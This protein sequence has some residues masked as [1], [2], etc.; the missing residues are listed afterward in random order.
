[1]LSSV[2]F[3]AS[4]SMLLWAQ[5][6]SSRRSPRSQQFERFFGADRGVAVTV[7][8]RYREL[9]RIPD[10]VD[11]FRYLALHGAVG[12]STF[13]FDRWINQQFYRSAQWKQ[14]RHY[15]IARD[16][17]CD[18]GVEGHE[19]YDRV[20]IHHMNPMLPDDI[21]HQHEDILDPEFLITVSHNTH[22][23]IHYGDERLL[24]RQ[25]V[26]RRPGDTIPWRRQH[27]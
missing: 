12:S 10:F 2:I 21:I 13:G 14:I 27:V 23:A 3:K 26:E 8:R 17:G 7:V 5:L 11:R 19:I 4:T 6:L 24:P 16:L 18:L 22:N 9:R 25:L 15:V 20:I 1:M